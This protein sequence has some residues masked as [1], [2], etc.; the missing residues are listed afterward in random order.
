MIKELNCCFMFVAVLQVGAQTAVPEFDVAAIR[1]ADSNTLS[2]PAV[3]VSPKSLIITNMSLLNCIQWAWSLP[4]GQVT[5]PTW[6]NDIHVAIDAKTQED[7]AE[8]EMHAKLASL[9][10][11]R[12]GVQV[13][14]DSK[15]E[16]V[17]ALTLAKDGPTLKESQTKGKA[18]ISRDKG[19]VV[20]QGATIDEF[21]TMLTQPLGRPVVNATGLKGVYD[22]RLD[23]SAYNADLEKSGDKDLTS[24]PVSMLIG[25]IQKQLGFKVINRSDKVE[26]L[27]VDHAEKTPTAN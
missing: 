2:K 15:L 9:L 25:A 5:G 4:P 21:A 1:I 24:D 26:I 17:F 8:A 14:R 23:V 18:I 6:L 11:R 27:V 12:F 16:T 3:Q 20:M 19:A 22:L 7:V 10:E 13:H